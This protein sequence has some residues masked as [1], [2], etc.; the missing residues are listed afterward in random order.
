MYLYGLEDILGV[1]LRVDYWWWRFGYFN[2]WGGEY[3][4]W[5]FNYDSFYWF[6]RFGVFDF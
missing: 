1:I 5:L 4:E 3:Y 6:L 2:V